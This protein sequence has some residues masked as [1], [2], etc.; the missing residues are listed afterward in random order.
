MEY[1]NGIVESETEYLAEVRQVL[2][3]RLAFDEYRKYVVQRITEAK[4]AGNDKVSTGLEILSLQQTR[5][6]AIQQYGEFEVGY[7]VSLIRQF[8]FRKTDKDWLLDEAV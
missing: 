2:K 4:Q 1:V 3:H 8:R 5:D 6:N 7:T